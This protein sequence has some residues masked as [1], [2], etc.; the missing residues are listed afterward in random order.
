MSGRGG[1]RG[2]SAPTRSCSQDGLSLV[3]MMVALLLL[4]IILSAAAASILSFVRE[5]S[6]NERRV[7][8]TAAIT[9]LH[10]DFQTVPY[11]LTAL[12]QSDVAVLEGLADIEGFDGIDTSG[13]QPEFEERPI[14]TMPDGSERDPRVPMGYRVGTLNEILEAEPDEELLGADAEDD[15]EADDGPAAQDI[16]EIVQVVTEID[17]SGDGIEDVRRLTTIVGWTWL[18]RPYVQRMD[19]ERA[20]TYFEAGDPS[21]ARAFLTAPLRVLVDGDGALLTDLELVGTFTT[22]MDVA[23]VEVGYERLEATVDADGNEQVT[24]VD[25]TMTLSPV[26]G[27]TT[28]FTGSV[29]SG[30]RFDMETGSADEEPMVA[31]R[32][33]GASEGRTVDTVTNVRLREQA[34]GEEQTVAVNLVTVQ[35]A[36]VTLTATGTGCAIDIEAVVDGMSADDYSVQASWVAGQARRTIS[37]EPSGLTGTA[38]SFL[39]SLDAGDSYGFSVGDRVRFDVRA[40]GNDGQDAVGSSEQEILIVGEGSGC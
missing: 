27:S 24:V 3:E 37:L 20:A 18:G 8:A 25:E 26:V 32:L 38:N 40:Q 21:E 28:R 4:G 31:F 2:H 1:A 6:A 36:E 16:Y 10:E 17:R 12:Y 29:P 13:P 5:A 39:G 34:G 33:V 23:T 7:Q 14:R 22:T 30:T 19:S 15:H 35:P 9:R 11:Q